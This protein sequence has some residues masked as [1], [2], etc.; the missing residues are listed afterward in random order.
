MRKQTKPFTVGIKPSRK[1]KSGQQKTPVWGKL[2]LR[3]DDD[4][5]MKAEPLV[6]PATAVGGDQF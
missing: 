2:D 4:L 5:Q 1:R 6:E 3:T